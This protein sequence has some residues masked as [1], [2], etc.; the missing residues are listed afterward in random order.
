MCLLKVLTDQSNDK[1]TVVGKTKQNKI[2][3]FECR[4]K[5]IYTSQSESASSQLR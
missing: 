1:R 4:N 5:F 2:N 3:T